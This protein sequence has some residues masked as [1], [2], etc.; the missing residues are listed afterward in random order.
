MASRKTQLVLVLIVPI[1]FTA[2]ADGKTIPVR[3]GESIQAAV[4]KAS[5]GDTVLI[6]CGMY[7]ENVRGTR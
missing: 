3:A 7:T 6:A 5:P 4:D 1:F 2:P